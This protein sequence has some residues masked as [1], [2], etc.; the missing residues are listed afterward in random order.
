MNGTHTSGKQVDNDET[1]EQVF[2]RYYR[3]NISL[4]LSPVDAP[5]GHATRSRNCSEID[6]LSPKSFPWRLSRL[7]SFPNKICFLSVRTSHHKAPDN[8]IFLAELRRSSTARNNN[9][10][11]HLVSFCAHSKSF[12]FIDA[13]DIIILSRAWTHRRTTP[14]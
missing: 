5:Q 3:R 10:T 2:G 11:V 1:H 12:S 7:K 4:G 13:A 6:F 9:P 8:A 14:I